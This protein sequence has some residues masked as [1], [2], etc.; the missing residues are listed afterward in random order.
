ARRSEPKRAPR[1]QPVKDQPNAPL[2]SRPQTS[3][4]LG[5][6]VEVKLLCVDLILENAGPSRPLTSIPA[7]PRS[8]CP[9]SRAQ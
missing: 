8:P 3:H 4:E 5:M 2:S 7:T 1:L 9:L 6:W